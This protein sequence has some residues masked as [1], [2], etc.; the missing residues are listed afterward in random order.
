[1]RVMNARRARVVVTEEMRNEIIRLLHDPGKKL[2]QIAR[3]VGCL[4]PAVSL[5]NKQAGIRIYPARGVGWVEGPGFKKAKPR[6]RLA[7]IGGE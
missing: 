2:I 4:Q 3:E 7:R 5:V 1:M 6:V